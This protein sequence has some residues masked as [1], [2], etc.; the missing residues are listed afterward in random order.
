MHGQQKS[1]FGNF[2]VHF[3]VGSLDIFKNPRSFW[4]HSVAMRSAQPLTDEYQGISLGM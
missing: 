2:W 1:K 3:P 4:P